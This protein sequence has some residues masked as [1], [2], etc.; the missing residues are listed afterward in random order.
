[1]TL[2]CV[3]ERCLGMYNGCAPPSYFFYSSSEGSYPSAG[4]FSTS[5]SQTRTQPSSE[6]LANYKTNMLKRDLDNMLLRWSYLISLLTP[7]N[8]SYFS[9]MPGILDCGCFWSI[10]FPCK[11]GVGWWPC[12]QEAIVVWNGNLYK[13]GWDGIIGIGEANGRASNVGKIMEIDAI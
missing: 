1:M 12:N 9:L 13:E 5:K 11:Y 8:G 3:Y 2:Y 7:W 6:Q 4:S 10:D